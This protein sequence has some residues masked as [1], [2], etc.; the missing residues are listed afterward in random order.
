MA[1]KLDPRWEGEWVVKSVK[2]SISTEN[3]TVNGLRLHAL[4]D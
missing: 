2:S 1:G 4:T 3:V